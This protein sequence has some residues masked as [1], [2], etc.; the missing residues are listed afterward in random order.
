MTR[1]AAPTSLTLRRTWPTATG[2]LLSV[3]WAIFNLPNPN[4]LRTGS[5][6]QFRCG[7]LLRASRSG[8]GC[9]RRALALLDR[10]FGPDDQFLGPVARIGHD[11]R[12]ARM[13]MPDPLPQFVGG[14][15]VG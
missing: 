1:A 7:G 15:A 14:A 6:P 11:R 9:D 2:G 12:F 13:D 4:S 10:F 5:F 8:G 3:L